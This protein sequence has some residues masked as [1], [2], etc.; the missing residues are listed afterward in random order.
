[1]KVNQ[2]SFDDL[3]PNYADFEADLEHDVDEY[4]LTVK[5]S[6]VFDFL[7]V[8]SSFEEWFKFCSEEMRLT[9]GKD[10][11]E[12]ESADLPVDYLI[13]NNRAM[14]LCMFTDSDVAHQVRIFFIKSAD[15]YQ[16]LMNA[17][18][19]QEF[20]RIHTEYIEYRK[21]TMNKINAGLEI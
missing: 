15:M 11:I 19:M 8:E 12:V 13:S 1:M 17:Q 7:R 5:A 21:K 16:E 3:F 9:S 18:N 14:H 10:Y 4:S 2:F 20:I 6:A